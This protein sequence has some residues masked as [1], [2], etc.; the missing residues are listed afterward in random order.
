MQH[1]GV[2]ALY[3]ALQPVNTLFFGFARKLSWA[4]H[5]AYSFIET[6]LAFRYVTLYTA[7][8]KKSTLLKLF[9]RAAKQM[10]IAAT[11]KPALF[12]RARASL[13]LAGYCQFDAFTVKMRPVS[14]FIME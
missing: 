2:R 9:F 4:S 14:D 11:K 5:V 12:H 7:T 10:V 13:C 1:F 3:L 8:Q 6:F